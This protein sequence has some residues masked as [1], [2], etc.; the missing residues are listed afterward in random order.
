[1]I[2]AELEDWGQCTFEK[3]PNSLCYED[4]TQKIPAILKNK[5]FWRWVY[6]E[7]LL[8]PKWVS[9]RGKRNRRPTRS[10]EGTCGRRER[11]SDR[12]A[13]AGL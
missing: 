3:D 8:F 4:F 6:I 12:V 9:S 11:V 2:V 13:K 7:F 10:A 5:E 1:M